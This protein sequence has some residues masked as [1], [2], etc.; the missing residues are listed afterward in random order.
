MLKEGRALSKANVE[1][2]K[3]AVETLQSILAQVEKN[4]PKNFHSLDP[5]KELIAEMK[6]YTIGGTR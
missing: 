1:S 4:E 5:F 6:G 2:L 3:S